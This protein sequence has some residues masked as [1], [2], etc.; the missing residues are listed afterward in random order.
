MELAS[1]ELDS[2]ELASVELASVDEDVLQ[3]KSVAYFLAS[4]AGSASTFWR[5]SLDLIKR[6]GA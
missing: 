6:F 5:M 4:I 1:V 2:V 3:H